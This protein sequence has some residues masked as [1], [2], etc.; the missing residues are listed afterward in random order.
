MRRIA[1]FLSPWEDAAGK[2]YQLIQSLIAI[3]SG[4]WSGVGLGESQQKLFYLPAAHTDFIFSVIAEELGFFGGAVLIGAF[5]FFLYRGLHLAGRMASD[6]FS[7]SL[8]V[9]CTSL[10]AIPALLNIGVTTGIL[11]TKGMVLPL[12]GYGG[13]SLV[14][15]L[16]SIGILLALWRNC[17]QG[18]K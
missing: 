11:P 16:M 10:I 3:G 9:G 2:G 7:Y 14:A 1:S 6:T 13:S 18:A 12:V 8:A 17:F 15:C 5:L 4:Q